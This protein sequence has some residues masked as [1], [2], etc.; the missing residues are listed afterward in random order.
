MRFTEI[1]PINEMQLDEVNM[2]PTNLRQLAS[3]IDARAGMEFE[4]IVPDAEDGDDGELEPDYDQDE[5]VSDIDDA[6]NF[7]YDGDYNSRRDIQSLRESLQED[8][9]NWVYEKIE[10]EWDNHGFEF[11]T[12]YLDREEPFDREEGLDLAQDY[13][14]E[15]EPDVEPGTDTYDELVS[16]R[17]NEMEAEYYTETW[18]A[19]GRSY[20]RAREEFESEKQDDYDHGDWLSDAGLDAMSDIARVYDVQWPHW[21]SVGGG[22][23]AVEDIAD[24]FSRAIGRPVNSSSSYHG[25]RR[26]EGTYVVE[27]DGSLEGEDPGDAGL[28]FVSPPLPIAELLS[29]LQKVKAWAKSE[30][31]YTGADFGTG[32]HI[33]VSV[34]GFT[35]DKLDYVKLAILLGDERVLSEFN[36][37]SNTYCKSAIGIVKNKIKDNPAA[38][39]GL[40]DQMKSH[41]EDMA[42]KAIHSGITTKFT[43]I[44]TKDGYVE[45]RSPGG[46]WL[47]EYYDKIEPTLL[48]FV[49][50]LDAAIDPQ[51]YRQEYLKKL[52]KLLAPAGE[53]S[54]MEYFAK[55]VAGEMPKLALKSFVR[56]AQLQ[57]KVA[58]GVQPGKMWWNVEWTNGRRMEVVAGSKEVAKQVAAEEW[59]IPDETLAGATVTPLRPYEEP[60]PGSTLDLQRQ[61]AAQSTATNQSSGATLNGRPSNPDGNYVIV[62]YTGSREVAYR[63]MASGGDDAQT[64]IR[65]WR[66]GHPDRSPIHRWAVMFD[67]DQSMGQPG[68]AASA[69]TGSWG[70]WIDGSQRFARRPGTGDPSI[71]SL[72]RY[73]SREEAS[74]FLTQLRAENPRMRTDIEIREIPADYQMPG[75][76]STS[77]SPDS[78]AG[79]LT[80]HGPGPWELY[81]TSTGAVFRRLEH[82]NRAAAA[83][84][85]TTYYNL[86]SSTLGDISNYAVR[87]QQ[88]AAAPQDSA[89]AMPRWRV[90]MGGEQVFEL[91]AATQAE[92]N[93]AART[94]ILGRS[95]E[96]LNDHRGQE[97]EVVPKQ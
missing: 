41:M 54:T 35:L 71:A 50:A 57:R 84:E 61:R 80:P 37:S 13:V 44:N 55:Y 2:S 85:A 39:Q 67:P 96:F 17:L 49:V 5:G 22:G 94:W 90:L 60:V 68:A 21:T 45:F 25:A 10:N 87:T 66:E 16:D 6:C 56:Q 78:T 47:N 31:C 27:P 86:Y 33:N 1:K 7:F 82:T 36:R 18:E 46:D 64:V 51:K 74:N 75:A 63:F 30:G 69:S 53:K 15:N 38:A 48:R 29:D 42:T 89:Q 77:A 23:R 8:Y 43:S 83:T 59:G 3:Q 24:N 52:Y 34:N 70:I 32:L 58:A 73:A 20:D 40:L 79:D 92:A 62:P 95:R 93:Q 11:F 28:E 81:N 9:A 91:D 72:R 97:V 76:S 26:E 88:Q 14:R 4:M 12:E 19:Q 65:Q